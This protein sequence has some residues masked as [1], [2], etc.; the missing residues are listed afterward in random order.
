MCDSPKW[1]DQMLVPSFYP[2]DT[3]KVELVQ[4]HI[5]WVFVCDEFVYKI[6]KPVDFGFLD[7][8]TLEKRR[9]FIEEELR[10]NRR[11]CPDIYL[12]FLALRKQ[13]DGQY[14]LGERDGGGGEVVEWVLKMKRMPEAGMMQGMIRREEIEGVHID[15]IVERLVPF[16]RSAATGG[17]VDQY[18]TLEKVWFNIQENFDQTKPFLGSLLDEE[19]Y[20]RIVQYNRDFVET[21]RG[22]FEER[23]SEHMIREGHGDLYS[24]NICFDEEKGDVYCFDCIEFNERFRCGDIACDL[25]FL[26]MD[27][28]FHGLPWFERRLEDEFAQAYGDG[29]LTLLMDFYK[30]YRAYVR[31]KIGCFMFNDQG[32]DSEAREKAREDAINYFALA[33]RYA[34]GFEGVRP[35]VYCFSGPSGTGK[36]TLAK[37]FSKTRG[38]KWFNSDV[39]RKEVI[40]GVPRAERHIEPFGKG[41]YSQE[42]TRRT[43]RSLM[44]HAAREVLFGRSVA[45]DATYVDNRERERLTGLEDFV[46]CKVVFIECELDEEI[47][48]KRLENRARKEGEPSDGRYEIYLAQKAKKAPF[49]PGFEKERLVRVNTGGTREENLDLLL[50]TLQAKGI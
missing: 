21:K 27:L 25:G 4:T 40:C 24:A 19:K 16:Y 29:S 1:L 3:S 35:T 31:A 9:H 18:G 32:L 22:L 50:R 5:S 28:D 2:E 30:C 12:D 44:R 38:I 23:I 6:K 10:L 13:E 49:D 37:D 47:V 34:G 48:K 7:F 20:Q 36:S 8:T 46:D 17:W 39:I 26:A 14:I 33:F 11:L 45:I 41:I 43:Y 15:R 42:F